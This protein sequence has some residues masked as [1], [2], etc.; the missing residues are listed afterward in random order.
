MMRR[1]TNLREVRAPAISVII[2]PVRIL[3]FDPHVSEWAP[4]KEPN[5]IKYYVRGLL[6]CAHHAMRFTAWAVNLPS[7]TSLS[8]FH[9]TLCSWIGR[10]VEIRIARIKAAHTDYQDFGK[11]CVTFDFGHSSQIDI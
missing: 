6:Q 3:D 8:T 10:V 11:W 1:L 4:E 5:K 7:K 9:V 2:G